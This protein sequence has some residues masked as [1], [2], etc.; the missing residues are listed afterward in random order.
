MLAAINL[1][2]P[3]IITCS[4]NANVAVVDGILQASIVWIFPPLANFVLER[5]QR[6]SEHPRRFGHPQATGKDVI[7]GH[8][9]RI[10]IVRFVGDAPRTR[11]PSPGQPA[12]IEAFTK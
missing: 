4:Q 10:F 6:Y 2:T 11:S 7:D 5:A 1:S 12:C 3:D 9:Q 8:F